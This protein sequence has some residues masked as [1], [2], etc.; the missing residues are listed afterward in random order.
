MGLTFRYVRMAIM[1]TISRSISILATGLIAFSVPLC[2]GGE[3]D[4][5][6][7]GESA[8]TEYVRGIL[9]LTLPQTVNPKTCFP[10]K[11]VRVSAS[12]SQVKLEECTRYPNRKAAVFEER[13]VVSSLEG[14][15]GFCDSRGMILVEPKFDFME[16]FS[17]GLAVVRIDGK[18]GY[19][20][21]D[22]RLVVKPKF[23]WAYPFH[24]GVG[25][26]QLKMLWGLIDRQGAWI[27]EPFFQR[28]DIL[29]GGLYA[30]T[31]DGTEGFIDKAGNFV[32]GGKKGH[33]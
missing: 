29:K 31:M 15:Y 14:K 10:Q 21:A 20:N 26:V 33:P 17:G 23:D 5:T 25:G 22:G 18:Y 4:V 24:D 32:A 9:V 28:L 12:D 27:K 2:A 19:V 3:R 8:G 11:F 1:A 7:G 13:V 16:S 6:R 30:V